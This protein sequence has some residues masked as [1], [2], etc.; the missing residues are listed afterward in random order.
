MY[1]TIHKQLCNNLK[2]AYPLH[3]A[4]N[5]SS[6]CKKIQNLKRLRGIHCTS[7]SYNFFL[8]FLFYDFFG[9]WQASFLNFL[10]F[11]DCCF[12]TFF[13]GLSLSFFF[14]L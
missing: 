13:L 8:N 1:K 9:F 5:S 14:L 6:F 11:L 3:V 7:K 2:I 4:V 12:Y 10:L